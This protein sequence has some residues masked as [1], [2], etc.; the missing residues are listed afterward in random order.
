MWR[1]YWVGA[2]VYEI[3]MKVYDER[4]GRFGLKG[5]FSFHLKKNTTWLYEGR[6]GERLMKVS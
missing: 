3:E 6:P 1:L 2:L 4:M 5:G